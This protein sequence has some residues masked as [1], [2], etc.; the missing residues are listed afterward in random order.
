MDAEGG[1]PGVSNFV[2]RDLDA[3]PS[4]SRGEAGVH[5]VPPVLA[6][7]RSLEGYG[8]LV[9]D[10]A[11][12]RV[13]IVTWP[14][15]GWRSIVPGTGNEG[16]VVEDVFEMTRRGSRQ[17]AVNHAVGRRYLTGWF[18][19]PARASDDAID[20]DTSRIYT[21]E[22]NY[23]PDGG[24]VFFPRGREPFVAMLANSGD[25]VHPEDFRAFWFDGSQGV[26]LAPGVW[27][28][29]VFPLGASVTF[30]DKQGRVHACVSVDFLGEFGVYLSVP[31][32][33][34]R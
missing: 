20:V 9:D 15:Q 29:P 12:A 5:A 3:M 4:I 23:H 14:A 34:P 25:D 13:K 8:H 32:T 16:G 1:L 6:T 2:G 17:W 22:A 28:Q 31:L 11:S 27:H 7:A 24:Q 26:H 30:D 33:R 10:F 21:H 18:D 19:D